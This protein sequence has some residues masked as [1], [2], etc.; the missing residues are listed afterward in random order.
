[1]KCSS[2]FLSRILVGMELDGELAERAL[3]LLRVAGALDAEDLVIVSLLVRLHLLSG[4]RA[5]TWS[6]VKQDGKLSMLTTP[7][8]VSRPFQ[9]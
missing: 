3:Q 2:A 5:A 7:G 1:M 6:N 8:A 4:R 9:D